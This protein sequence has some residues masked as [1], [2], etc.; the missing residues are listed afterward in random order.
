MGEGEPGSARVTV[1]VIIGASVLGGALLFS[2]AGVEAF[3]IHHAEK[4]ITVTGSATRRIKSD[5]VVWRAT[6]KSQATEMAAAY[7]KLAADVPEVVA[8]LKA[9]GVDEKQMKVASAT[10]GE[11][12]PRD[13]EGHV[14]A[15]VTTAFVTEQSIE[16]SS[17]DIDKVETTSREVTQLID[18]G[19]YITSQAPLYI[20]TK[21]PELKVSMLADASKDAYD[22]ASQIA[23]HA[24]SHVASLLVA[25]MGVMQVNPA[26]STEVS[27]EGN[28]DK[29]SLEKDALA[30]VTASFSID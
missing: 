13:K 16:V 29:S 17:A 15:E 26:Y 20:Y 24:G 23:G 10:I 19:I 28:N 4:R 6:V 7:K 1:A 27:S 30:I 18:C 11:L 22:R 3:R 5:F 9:H 14:V 12:H 8:F 21:L 25:K 2:R